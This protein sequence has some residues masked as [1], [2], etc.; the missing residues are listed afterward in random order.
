MRRAI[1]I[2]FFVL[3]S[4]LGAVA[5]TDADATA[6][7]DTLLSAED[8]MKML[9]APKDTASKVIDRGHDIS[10]LVNVRR[11]RSKDYTPFSSTSFFSNSFVSARYTTIGL[12]THEADYSV[13]LAGG[14][15][16]GKWLHEDHAVRLTATIGKWKENY[17]GGQIRPISLDASY[18]FNLSSYVGGYRTNRFCEV[19]VVAGLGYSNVSYQDQSRN[20][21]NGHVGANIN[22]RLFKNFDL[23]FE[24]VA[25]IYNNEMAVLYNWRSWMPS[26]QATC[27]ITYNIQQAKSPDSPRLLPRTD[28]WFVSFMA[29]PQVQNSDLVNDLVGF[30]KALG[31]HVNLGVGKYYTD[32][33]AMRYS[34]AYSRHTWNVW[35]GKKLHS[36]YFAFRAEGMLD[37]VGLIRAAAGKEGNSA[38]ALSLLCGPEIG[39][40]HKVDTDESTYPIISSAYMSFTGGIQAKVDVNRRL[41]L[42]VEPRYSVVPYAA[43]SHDPLNNMYKNFYDG[44][45]NLN[46]GIEFML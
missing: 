11:Q 39:Y 31:V 8:V 16:F 27:G 29:G 2:C 7:A 6:P 43:P 20:A 28:G 46:F 30:G 40:M 24:P 41:S 4:C 14:L 34:A 13:G 23:F 26:V 12:L 10:H 18:L 38:F 44:I 17:K 22:I 25:V 19:M 36:N 37:F 9:S 1:S 45:M 35:G 33:F 32:W 42:F 21:F 3:F 5:Q 15:S